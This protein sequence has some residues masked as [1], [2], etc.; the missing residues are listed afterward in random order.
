M[1]FFLVQT[2]PLPFLPLVTD[3]EVTCGEDCRA[4]VCAWHVNLEKQNRHRC[5]LRKR[6]V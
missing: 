5:G 1:T 4:V 2:L 6:E 3:N